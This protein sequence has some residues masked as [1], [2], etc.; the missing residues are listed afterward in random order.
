MIGIVFIHLGQLNAAANELVGDLDLDHSAILIHLHSIRRVIH[1]I[2]LR[3]SDFTNHILAIRDVRKG[4]AA[5]LCGNSGQNRLCAVSKEETDGSSGQCLA[6]L[7]LLHAV[8]FSVNHLVGNALSVIDGKLHNGNCLTGIGE[9]HR[10]LL[11]GENVVAVGADFLDIVAAEGNIALEH[12]LSV[13]IKGH[14]LDETV[15]RNDGAVCCGKLLGGIEA[16]GHG[17]K[18]VIHTDTE[19]LVLLQYLGKRNPRLLSVIAEAGSRFGDLN[20]LAGVDK[21]CSMGVL[22]YDHAIGGFHLGDFVFSQIQRLALHHAICTCGHRIYHLADA[23][24]QRAVRSVDVRRCLDL[25]GCSCKTL[26]RID[27]LVDPVRRRDGGK[28]LADFGNLDDALL[29]VVAKLHCNDCNAAFLGGILF[30]HIKLDRLMTE[31][32]AVR[33]GD[34]LEGVA[35]AKLQL[36]RRDEHAGVIGVEGVDGGNLRI[37]KGHFHLG[38]IRTKDLEARTRIGNGIAGLR[39]HLDDLNEGLEVGVVDEVA[40]GLTVLGNE[41]IKVAHQLTAFPAGDLMHGVHAVG[42]VLALGKAIFIAGQIVPL[43]ILCRLIAAGRFQIDGEYCTLLGS[44][45]LRIAVIR[46]LDDGDIALLHLLAHSHGRRSVQLNGV[47]GRFCTDRINDAVQKIALGGADLT[48]R[49]VITANIVAGGELAVL[50]GVVGIRKLI[51]LINAVGGTGKRSVALR[52]S[53]LTVALSDGDIEFLED[54]GKALIGYAVPFHCGTLAVG[55]HIANGGVHLLQCVAGADEHIPE[56]RHTVFIG[57]SKFIH[58][59]TAEGGSKKV[60]LHTLVQSVLGGLGHGQITAA[61]YIVEGNRR[62]LSGEHGNAVAFLGHILVIT[63]LSDG[64]DTG[65]QIV[66]ANFTVPVGGNGLIDALAGDGEGN[67]IHLAVLAGLDNFSASIADLQLDKRFYGVADGGRIGDGILNAAVGAVLIV[68]PNKNAAAGSASSCGDRHIAAGSRIGGDSER[69]ARHAEMKTR[70]TGG[71]GKLRQHAVGIRE[72]GNVL[73]AVPRKLNGLCAAAASAHKA[74]ANDVALHAVLDAVVI[75][76]DSAIQRMIGGNQRQ[77]LVIAAGAHMVKVRIALA[78]NR[79]PNEQLGSKGVGQLI[80]IGIV[81]RSPR[82][83]KVALIAILHDTAQQQLNI[84]RLDGVVVLAGI[85]IPEILTEAVIGI[86]NISGKAG[87]D[88]V[89]H[90]PVKGIHAVQGSIV[91]GA[92]CPA[93]HIVFRGVSPCVLGVN[94][95]SVPVTGERNH[96]GLRCF[97]CG[98]GR[99]RAK[100]RKHGE[101]H[102]DCKQS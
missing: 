69:I 68:R 88:A 15:H 66:D 28:H 102:K 67:A 7:V 36:L 32:I 60:E 27:R 70:L 99:C 54:V 39:V 84:I 58:G 90:L 13:F 57:N 87:L 26:H 95:S 86:A 42:Q 74:R 101:C 98:E 10:V 85:V 94:L 59:Q 92:C 49:P 40:V 14:D 17:G 97:A 64:I 1:H 50:V 29:R 9:G 12:S 31:H 100:A 46:V 81:L 65:H 18:L 24:A 62:R 83:G 44:F 45:D 82:G 52:R 77:D 80:R 71:E 55:N 22:V 33:S 35:L 11:I 34:L 16:E 51:A 25:I 47:I 3:C 38:A 53:N 78:H 5:V 61:E 89:A 41:H 43:R 6:V 56:N 96:I 75:V 93:V 2:A 19:L 20:F 21:F 4:E 37:G 91:A 48:N 63:L 72:L 8:D 30:G 79:F 76:H 23:A 73:T